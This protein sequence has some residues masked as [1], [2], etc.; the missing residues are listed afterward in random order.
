[1]QVQVRVTPKKFKPI[2][3]DKWGG[4][5][6]A[7]LFVAAIVRNIVSVIASF[8]GLESAAEMEARRQLL[9]TKQ[10]CIDEAFARAKAELLA[11]PEDQYAKLLAKLA[12]KA[13]KTGREEI[14]LSPR[15]RER[16][17]TKV[18]AQ[19]NALLAQAAAPDLPE[20]LQASR[21]GSVIA[22]VVTGASALLQGTAM[23]TLSDETRDIEGGL[24]LRSGHVEI[25]CAFETQLRM[26]RETMAAE[27]AAVL[28]A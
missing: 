8:S 14:L 9:A 15:D 23:L 19:A 3:P 24:I 2:I 12:A 5:I 7:L 10:D 21:A 18:V 27:I 13:A 6:W 1:M 20:E 22:K 17:G 16:V 26:L 25:N 4:A 11:L 28:F